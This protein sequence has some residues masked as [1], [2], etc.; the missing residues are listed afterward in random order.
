MGARALAQTPGHAEQCT[1][2]VSDARACGNAP[3]VHA[4]LDQKKPVHA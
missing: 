3:Q 1:T 4:C 2:D